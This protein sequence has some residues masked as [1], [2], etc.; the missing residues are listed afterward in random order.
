MTSID[1]NC[2]GQRIIGLIGYVYTSP[3]AGSSQIIYR[4]RMNH[5]DHFDSPSSNC[6]GQIAEGP[7]GYLS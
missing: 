1:S 4:C 2:E 5:G 7:I 3:P 6:E